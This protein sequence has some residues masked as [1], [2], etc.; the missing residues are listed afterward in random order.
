MQIG[1]RI[2]YEIST[3]NVILDKGEMQGAVTQ[4][5]IADDIAS[6]K[7]LSERNRDTFAYIELPF[8]AYAQDFAECNGYRIHLE[9]K[10]P[11]FSYPDPNEPTAPPV[12]QQPLTEQISALDERL[13]LSESAIDFLIMNGGL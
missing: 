7:A 11:V 8:E 5:T 10:L 13:A 9:T 4:T 3:G 1:R 12:F 6:Y 2:Y